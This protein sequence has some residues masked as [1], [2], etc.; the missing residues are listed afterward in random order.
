MCHESSVP[1]VG[2]ARALAE[3]N[4]AVSGTDEEEDDEVDEDDE[5]AVE[6]EGIV[7]AEDFLLTEAD[8]ADFGSVDEDCPAASGAT[9][10]M[11]SDDASAAA[12]PEI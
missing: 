1:L 12:D 7:E 3:G 6:R 8:A 2:A 10:C 9:D 4:D 5:D 11:L